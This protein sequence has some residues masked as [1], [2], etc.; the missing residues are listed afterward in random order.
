MAK[1]KSRWEKP[2]ADLM[3]QGIILWSPPNSFGHSRIHSPILEGFQESTLSKEWRTPLR[4]CNWTMSI[5]CSAIVQIMRPLWKKLAV[6][7]T[8]L[9]GKGTLTTGGQVSGMPRIS[10]RHI[11]SAKN[12]DWISLL[13]S[14]LNTTF[15]PETSF[16]SLIAIFSRISLWA[17]RYGPLSP[18]EY[19]LESTM[20]EFLKAVGFLRI[21]IWS[22]STTIT[23]VRI[24]NKKLYR[25]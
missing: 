11:S 3:C 18:V 16:N 12:T 1:D 17:L 4:K 23:L 8:G 19:W 14:S 21:P 9:S 10:L 15:I 6:L 13:L 25:L 24:R 20:R 7:S 5:S 22:E 2:F